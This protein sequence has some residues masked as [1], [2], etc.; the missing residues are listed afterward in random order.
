MHTQC[1]QGI[2][3]RLCIVVSGVPAAVPAAVPDALLLR[4]LSALD[5]SGWSDWVANSLQNKFKPQSGYPAEPQRHNPSA[6]R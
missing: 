5:Q 3:C 2:S 1:N 4:P 6:G